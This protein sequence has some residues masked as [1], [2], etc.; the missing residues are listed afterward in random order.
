MSVQPPA[1]EAEPRQPKKG[2]TKL[3]VPLVWAV[4]ILLGVLLTST[5]RLPFRF[6]PFGFFEQ[7]RNLLILHTILS[8][9]IIALQVALVIVYLRVYADT[10]ARFALG[11][12]VVMFA[13][14]VQSFLQY[15]LLLGY[16]GTYAISFGP[17][18]TSGDLFTMAAYSVILYLSLE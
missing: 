12:L 4:G 10:R 5:V 13:L 9:V 15:P 18:L 17:Y 2:T 1:P 6:G 3:L 7:F 11:I 14:L 8:T 16:V